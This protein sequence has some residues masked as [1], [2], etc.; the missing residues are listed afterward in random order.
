MENFV[1]AKKLVR[2]KEIITLNDT[3]LQRVNCS[4]KNSSKTKRNK[5]DNTDT[6]RYQ[7]RKFSCSEM[8]FWWGDLNIGMGTQIDFMIEIEKNL[9]YLPQHYELDTSRS[10]RNNQDTSV[11][12]HEQN[13]LDLCNEAKLTILNGRT[14]GDIQGNL[15]YVALENCVLGPPGARPIPSLRKQK[16]FI[17][18]KIS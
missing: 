18:K 15:T 12:Q 9:I 7:L 2:I 3:E 1:G 5:C 10:V 4:P 16:K 8:V 11:N 13:L 17:P 14:R 6:L